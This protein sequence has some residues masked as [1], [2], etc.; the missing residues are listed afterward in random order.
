MV[1]DY[2]EKADRMREQNRK[3]RRQRIQE[4]TVKLADLLRKRKAINKEMSVVRKRL[5][6]DEDMD[7][8]DNS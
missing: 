8:I 5:K 1:K 7:A 2:I 4:N 3:D 6:G